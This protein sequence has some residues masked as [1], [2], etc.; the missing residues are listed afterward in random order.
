MDDFQ[1]LGEGTLVRLNEGDR[2]A[3]REA[4]E[5]L[6]QEVGEERLFSPAVWTRSPAASLWTST[7]PRTS[8][9]SFTSRAGPLSL[10]RLCRNERLSAVR[11]PFIA[12]T[13]N[14][15]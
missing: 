10:A 15:V 2:A 6:L 14:L 3:L 9:A 8:L 4:A 5:L 11:A 13:E 12:A 1:D 7:S